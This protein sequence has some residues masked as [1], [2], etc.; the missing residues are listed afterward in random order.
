MYTW[1]SLAVVGPDGCSMTYPSVF[2]VGRFHVSPC[3]SDAAWGSCLTDPSSR[4]ERNRI[5]AAKFSGLAKSALG[6][7]RDYYR[8]IAGRH[9]LFEGEWRPPGGQ[10]SP[11]KAEQFV[12]APRDTRQ[13]P[14]GAH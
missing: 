10:G 8:S 4:M 13:G 11:S 2:D 14:E 12:R 5:E 1:H 9:L 3:D 6:L 7:L